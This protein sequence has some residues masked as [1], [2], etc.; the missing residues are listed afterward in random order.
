MNHTS[1]AVIVT[2]AHA[3]I[4]YVNPA[5]ERSSGYSRE[6]LIGQN[7]RI[8]KSGIQPAAFYD[9]MWAR[10]ASGER[11]SGT[12]INRRKDGTLY[13]EAATI[14]PVLSGGDAPVGYVAVKRDLT[15][16]RALEHSLE[17]EVRERMAV[18]AAAS[19]IQVGAT[20]E[21][22]ADS[23]VAEAARLEGIDLVVLAHL[24]RDGAIVPLSVHLPPG[25]PLHRG[26]PIPAAWAD[27]LRARGS[28]TDWSPT[29]VPSPGGRYLDD[30]VA[31]S[32]LTATA[33]AQ[34]RWADHVVGFLVCGTTQADGPTWIERRV[35]ATSELAAYASALL[36]P[37]L[38]ERE[39]TDA[40]TAR[41]AA[42]VS[43]RAF[44]PVFQPIV[45]I[46]GGAV[47]GYEALTR[48]DNGTPPDQIF[49]Q[50]A[51]VGLQSELELACIRAAID[52]AAA[53]PATA[54]ISINASPQLLLGSGELPGILRLS[55]HRVVLEVTEHTAVAD[56]EE[57]RAASRKFGPDVR[58]SID[59]AGAGYASLRHVIELDADFVKLDFSLIHGIDADR[60]R[61]ALVAGIIHYANETDTI[62]IAEGVETTGEAALLQRLG[63]P[64]AQ[65]YLYAPPL[66]ADQTG[67][68][69]SV[70]PPRPTTQPSAG[71]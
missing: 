34:L 2:D 42:I 71:L 43:D 7:P 63:V 20:P 30:P 11:W 58:I 69:R 39:N 67:T 31:V 3:D 68:T 19:R 66:P 60:A 25:V 21:A 59:D 23:V 9:A 32:G 64:L 24:R 28:T 16:E 51:T 15:R 13:E 44:Q 61:E 17:H 70:T 12:M 57:L 14:S 5:V 33:V 4:V 8:F 22:T 18:A 55:T 38:S 62:L 29:L 45:R 41:L 27:Y 56:Y 54:W 37:Q 26:E 40:V 1:E 47:V 10:V 46:D 48:F 35:P 65:G 53:L 6:E 49:A 52:A 36:G 50:A